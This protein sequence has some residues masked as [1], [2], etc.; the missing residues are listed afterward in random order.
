LLLAALALVPG[1]IEGKND[2]LSSGNDL[3]RSAA[4]EQGGGYRVRIEI[5]GASRQQVA[6]TNVPARKHVR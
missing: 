5:S 3:R 4:S 6:V 1:G 2:P